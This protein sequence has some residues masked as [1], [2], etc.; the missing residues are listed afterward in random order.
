MHLQ[1]ILRRVQPLPGFVYDKVELR[2]TGAWL[3]VDVHVRPRAESRGRCGHCGQKRPGYDTLPERRFAFVPL[4]GMAVF[5]VYAMRR[6]NC[7]R[8]GVRVE[9]VPWA[10][11][12][13]PATHA[14]TWFLASWAKALSWT[15]T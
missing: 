4:W 1:S 5:F 9:M 10:S 15:E 6:V 12:K 7:G 14:Y 13:S 3:K 11:G 2:E 8:C